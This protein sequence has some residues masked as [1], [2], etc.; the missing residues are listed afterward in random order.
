[1]A[2]AN[3]YRDVIELVSPP[4]RV[5]RAVFGALAPLARLRGRDVLAPELHDRCGASR[6]PAPDDARMTAL[7]G[8]PPARQPQAAVAQPPVLSAS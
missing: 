6:I 5:Q 4:P 8:P 3:E 7:L 2:L 1:V